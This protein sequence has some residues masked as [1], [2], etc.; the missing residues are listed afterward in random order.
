MN[1]KIANGNGKRWYDPM[2]KLIVILCSIIG[3]FLIAW[4]GMIWSEVRANVERSSENQRTIE[5]QG[6]QNKEILRRLD[7]IESKVD[8]R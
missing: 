2:K 1:E 7:R 5:R 8:N 3:F 4:G 6:A